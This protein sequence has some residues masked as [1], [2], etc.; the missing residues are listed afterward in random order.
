MNYGL[1]L[2]MGLPNVM[3]YRLQILMGP[4]TYVL[5]GLSF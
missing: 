4:Q 5:S 1:K 3:N 2:L